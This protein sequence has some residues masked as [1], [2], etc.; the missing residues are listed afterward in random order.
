M[1]AF[2][3]ARLHA[4]AL[5]EAKIAGRATGPAA[6]KSAAAAEG[7]VIKPVPPGD[8][9]IGT[10]DAKLL[11]EWCSIYVRN[12]VSDAEA[13]AFVAHELGHLKLHRPQDNCTG[14]N[15]DAGTSRALSRVEAYGPRERRELQANVF[16][17][18]LLLPRAL[19]RQ[20]FL[21]ERLGAGSIAQLLEL[22]VPLVRRQLFD[23]LL[24]P[25]AS[26]PTVNAQKPKFGRD[27]S[28]E[29]AAGFADPALLLEAGPGSG[30]T[31]T[32]VK[33]IEHLLDFDEAVP[34]EILALTFSNKAAG[35]L[36][37]R[38]ATARPDAA[39]DMWI[40]TFHAFGLDLIRRYYELL[41][42][43]S[44]VQLIDKAQAIELLEDQLPLMGLNHYHDLRN[45]D[46]G[47]VKILSAISR[48]KDELVTHAEF[49][50]RAREA[51]AAAVSAEQVEV[52]ERACEAAR[53]YEIYADALG[54]AGAVDFG[55]LVMLPT[56]LMMR[57]DCVRAQVAQRHSMVLVDEYQDVN[58][59]SAR[60]LMELYREGARLWVVGDARQSLYRWRGAS[61]ANMAQFERDFSGGKRLPLDRNYRSTEHIVGLGRGFARD[62]R[63]G[64]NGLAYNA[65]SARE[66]PGSAT[67]LL[68]GLDDR[69]EG[70]LLAAEITSLKQAGVP[71]S[72]QA[73][74]APT[75]N[76]LDIVAGILAEHGI[77][78]THLGSF[79]EREEVR[80][81]LSVIA[82]L[83]EANG[84]ALVRVAALREIGVG[85]SDI[86]VIVR[87]A[88]AAR[89]PLLSLLAT[90]STLTG[91]SPTGGE[92]LEQ[93]GLQM[94]GLDQFTPAFEVA[95]SWLLDRSDYLRDLAVAPD[96]SG[97]LSRAALLAL[98]GFLDQRELGGQPLTPA[99]ALKRMRSTVLLADDRDLRDA[100][101]GADAD[102]V[103]LMTIHGAKG[104]EFPAVHVVGL[105][106]QCL[107]G[108]FRRD[109]SPL[110]PGLVE[111]ETRE[112]HLEEEECLFFVAISRAEDH[113][114]LYHSELANVR[115]R[116]PSPFLGRLGALERRHL[117]AA[118]TAAGAA[119][120][121]LS[122]ISTDRINLFDV[123]DFDSCPLRIAYRRFFGVEG[124][125]HETPYLKTSGV[126]YALVDRITEVSGPGVEERLQVL[127]GEIWAIRGPAEHG[128]AADYLA[129]A[130]GRAAALGRLMSGFDSPG[131]SQIELPINGGLLTVA[132][133]LVRSTAAGTEIRFLE[134]G[135][136]RS[137]TGNDLTAGLLLAAA[138][139]TFGPNVSV[140]IGHVTDG[141]TVPVKRQD[142]KA[143]GDVEAAA[144]ILAA[145]NKGALPA[146]P[147]MRVCGRCPHFVACPAVGRAETA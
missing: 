74:L 55:D 146:K 143:A 67:R 56:L 101:L 33:R 97:S 53:V 40:G 6:V 62:M 109:D 43:P 108:A 57:N 120:S 52:A 78:T 77:A 137:K 89:V 72:Q 85:A 140:T 48:A 19:A 130:A 15:P 2:D 128:L 141:A 30:K 20:L 86:G 8:P 147:A 123:R 118:A 87:A 93:L 106:D 131:Y 73:V 63:A 42:L 36:A 145:I 5:R 116:K 144:A 9:V 27:D 81:L 1:A 127:L 51:L 103:R 58:R 83:A 84:G 98:L 4:R 34:N 95:A 12:D 29:A 11:R 135:R 18:E 112:G 75:N 94:A 100:T 64:K 32:L 50:R 132:A 49:T 41:D 46:Q 31:R 23:S 70:E 54:K 66:E 22:P 37:D 96:A 121:P 3:L 105:H 111:P 26:A 82:L 139:H 60:L 102:A 59:A 76:R 44:N 113:L 71:L 99:R 14:P 119:G 28:Q 138:R 45:P 21:V 134:A 17:R 133:P 69:C 104:L 90:A 24:G 107:P 16:A 142:D 47:L 114:R 110:P 125:R 61:S 124:R 88:Q 80:D 92:A 13:A 10:S 25:D 117:P 136:V 65:K 126:L 79:F 35:E 68:V 39:A 122:P 7:F 38:I 129:H 91:M 115:G